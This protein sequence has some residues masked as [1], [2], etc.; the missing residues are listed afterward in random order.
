MCKFLELLSK[1]R[2][3]WRKH[4]KSENELDPNALSGF[5]GTTARL[6]VKAL[7]LKATEETKTLLLRLPE[8][9]KWVCTDAICFV[10]VAEVMKGCP[11][12]AGFVLR[13]GVSNDPM[14]ESAKEAMREGSVKQ[15]LSQSTMDILEKVSREQRAEYC[16][17]FER[18]V[19]RRKTGN[20]E[21]TGIGCHKPWPLKIYEN[22]KCVE[23]RKMCY[24]S[25]VTQLASQDCEDQFC[26]FFIQETKQTDP[27]YKKRGLLHKKS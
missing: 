12:P 8:T 2:V 25:H 1:A 18:K 13:Q 26:Y 7:L 14:G 6:Y 21:K 5:G 22:G 15:I 23:N 3:K 4:R 24:K 16:E 11:I 20:S 19:K 27:A 9:A 17:S 10:V